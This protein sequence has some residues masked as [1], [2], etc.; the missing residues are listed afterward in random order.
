MDGY[1][2]KPVRAVELFEALGRVVPLM[3]PAKN[4]AV[5]CESGPQASDGEATGC[6]AFDADAALA[7]VEGDMNVLRKMVQLFAKQSAELLAEIRAANDRGDS[8]ALERAAHKLKGSVAIF[9]APPAS[10]LALRL[11]VMGRQ[12]ELANAASTV[13]ELEAQISR[14]LQ[15]LAE[16]TSRET[17]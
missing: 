1:V 10:E 13:A 2:A 9:S 6:P 15:A 4:D 3:P 5:V 8:Q 17:P 14:L 16:F 7:R 12:G 11:E